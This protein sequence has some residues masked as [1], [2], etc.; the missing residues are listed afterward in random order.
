[1]SIHKTLLPTGREFQLHILAAA[2]SREHL[3]KELPKKVKMYLGMP[4]VSTK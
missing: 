1:M 4:V 3:D 2:P